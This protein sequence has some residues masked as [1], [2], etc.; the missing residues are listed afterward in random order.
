MT[1]QTDITLTIDYRIVDGAPGAIFLQ[2]LAQ[3]LVNPTPIFAAE[4]VLSEAE[5]ET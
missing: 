1:I 5:G 4:P 2:T 3:L